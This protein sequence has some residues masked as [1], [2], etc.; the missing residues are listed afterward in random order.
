MTGIRQKYT[1]A[2]GLVL[3]MSC[4]LFVGGCSIQKPK[5]SENPWYEKWKAMAETSKG[6]TPTR[7][8]VDKDAEKRK[9]LG[10]AGRQALVQKS[11]KALPTRK[12]TVKLREMEVSMVLR[13]VARAVDQNILINE[14]VQGTVTVDVKN[15]PWNQVFLGILRTHGLSYAWEGDIIRVMT[16]EDMEREIQRDIRTLIVPIEYADAK[17]M[18]E[19][20]QKIMTSEST[21]ITPQGQKQTQTAF[22]GSVLVDEHNNALILQATREDIQRLVPIIEALDRPTPQIL[23]EAHIVEATKTA[24]RELGVQWGGLYKSGNQWIYPGVAGSSNLTGNPLSAPGEPTTGWAAN[25]P[26][27]TAVDAAAGP[28]FSLGYMVGLTGE[29]ILSA[30]LLALQNDGKVNILSSPSITT[31]DNQSAIVESGAEVPFQTVD[32]NG[33]IVIEFKKA[34]LSLEV[35]PHVIEGDILKLKIQTKKDEL[36]F[37]QPVL[38]NPTILTKNAETNVILADGETTVIGGL[39]K[40]TDN[41]ADFGVPGLK[42]IPILGWLFKTDRTSEKKEEVLIFITPYILKQRM[43]KNTADV[44]VE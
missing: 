20:I 1:M 44:S 28:I 38:G 21:T 13:A 7:P 29:S 8:K 19:N 6:F 41:D 2:L 32:E 14:A 23:I 25:F 5:K 17:R 18:Q 37:T 12:I 10:Y 33:N 15:V 42:D 36:D 34:T 9:K 40:T 26:L 16:A 11:G 22:S 39:N 43:P 35:T 3:V 4:L 30:Q 24:A 31:L 27:S